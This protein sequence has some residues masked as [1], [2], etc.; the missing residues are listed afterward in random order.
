MKPTLLPD[1]AQDMFFG[2]A[3]FGKAGSIASPKPVTM[4]WP[5][6]W[7]DRSHGSISEP[8]ASVAPTTIRWPEISVAVT[9]SIIRLLNVDGDGAS[10]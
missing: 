10:S 8:D 1:R 2:I 9:C 6:L 4:V 5:T 3:S 7:G